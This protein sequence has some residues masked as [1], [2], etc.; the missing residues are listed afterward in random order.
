MLWW[1]LI[2]V[3]SDHKN[4]AQDAL[5]LTSDRVYHLQLL[6]APEIVYING[7]HKTVVDANSW[8]VYNPKVK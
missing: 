6:F 2:K 7:I 1:Q 5:G 3:Y 8:L 4:L